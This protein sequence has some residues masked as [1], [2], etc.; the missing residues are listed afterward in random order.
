MNSS[1]TQVCSPAFSRRDVESPHAPGYRER[2]RLKSGL[3]T[4]RA[5]NVTRQLESL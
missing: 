5:L 2:N 4:I 3:Q 1:V